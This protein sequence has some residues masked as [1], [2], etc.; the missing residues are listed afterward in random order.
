[1]LLQLPWKELPW[2]DSVR[3]L[4]TRLILYVDLRYPINYPIPIHSNNSVQSKLAQ[5]HLVHISWYCDCNFQSSECSCFWN[6]EEIH[7]SSCSPQLMETS[8]R[9]Q[10]EEQCSNVAYGIWSSIWWHRRDISRVDGTYVVKL[11]I[12]SSICYNYVVMFVMLRE[13]LR[14]CFH[15]VAG[16]PELDVP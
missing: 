2:L 5:R 1:M 8:R 13:R 7:R 4:L 11:Y 6:W 9:S 15:N 16:R 10:R 3:V 12:W 14:T